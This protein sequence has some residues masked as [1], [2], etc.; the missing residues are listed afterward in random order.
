MYPPMKRVPY[1]M[2]RGIILGV[3]VFTSLILAVFIF[4]YNRMV[5][6]QNRMAHREQLGEVAGRLSLNG[7]NMLAEYINSGIGIDPLI[8]SVAPVLFTNDPIPANRLIPGLIV[9]GAG[10]TVF[11]KV[12][13]DYN[14][15]LEQLDH[16]KGVL[17]ESPVCTEMGIS[18]EAVEQI[19]PGTSDEQRQAGRDPVEKS[20]EAVLMCN[21]SYAG[22][23]RIAKIRRQ[24]KLISMVPGVYS[25]FSL[26]VPYT[27]NV[28]SFNS[29]G[30]K[31]NGD[32]DTGYEHPI[33]FPLK[34]QP[35]RI[36]NGTDSYITGEVPDAKRDLAN[37]GWIFLGP[38]RETVGVDGPV[39]LKVPSG[40]NNSSSLVTPAA[41]GHFLFSRPV[42]KPNP[43]PPPVKFL[44]IPPEILLP[45]SPPDFSFDNLPIFQA[46]I[47]GLYQGFYTLDPEKANGDLG[48]GSA[49]LWSGLTTDATNRYLCASSWLMPFGDKDRPSRTLVVGNVLAGFLKFY[50]IKDATNDPPLYSGKITTRRRLS[51]DPGTAAVYSPADKIEGWAAAP[52]YGDVF[53]NPTSGEIGY[54]S[55]AKVVPR[56]FTSVEIIAGQLAPVSFNAF[57]DCLMYPGDFPGIWTF[58][59]FSGAGYVPMIMRNP[60]VN[61]PF[62]IPRCADLDLPGGVK[63]V[64]PTEM[65]IRFTETDGANPHDNYYFEGDLAQFTIPAFSNTAVPNPLKN[66]VTHLVDLSKCTSRAA[67][68]S[69]LSNLLFALKVYPFSAPPP[70]HPL[71]AAGSWYVPK[72]PGNFFIKRRRDG[73]GN[74]ASD[75]LSLPGQIFLTTSAIIIL[76]KGDLVIPAKILSP[77]QDGVPVSLLSLIAIE[78]NIVLT[79]NSEIDAYLVAL[80]RGLGFSSPGGRLLSDSGITRMNIVGGLAIWEMGLYQAPSPTTVATTMNNFPEGGTITYNPRFNPSSPQFYP[81][82]RL[83]I[84]E[85]KASSIVVAGGDS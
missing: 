6:Q 5:R 20:G 68:E 1:L 67:E 49:G 45:G 13:N 78:G 51:S 7:V 15:Y 73:A 76:E 63:G 8:R 32:I 23:K 12:L 64:H 24:F 28:E 46:I 19:S 72:Q 10:T 82:S 43:S 37:R 81:Q 65:V 34:Y 85:D 14:V 26:F 35:L 2:R 36:F 62:F 69:L 4:S 18:F 33:P 58:P 66:R 31:Y 27:P 79:T 80:K 55:F 74:P 30:T 47:G 84:M 3:V 75:R 29:V 60:T 53:L 48:A 70:D 44:V 25:R 77:L 42:E 52:T 11:D 40:Y 22:L 16:L 61:Q 50:F 9:T 56:C 39:L 41:G 71:A 21:V 38:S 54:D 83:F 57:F 17:G 59:D